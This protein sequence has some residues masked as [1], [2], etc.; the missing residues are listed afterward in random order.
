MFSADGVSKA[1]EKALIF[2]NM[3]NV[4]GKK[5]LHV[6]SGHA[7]YTMAIALTSGRIPH[8]GA[9]HEHEEEVP[10]NPEVNFL[11]DCPI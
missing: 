5:A 8:A 11:H 7:N 2:A 4:E 10:P 9:E 1:Y 6:W 3:A